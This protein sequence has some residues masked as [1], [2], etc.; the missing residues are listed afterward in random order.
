LASDARGEASATVRERA[1]AARRLQQERQGCLNAQLKPARLRQLAGLAPESRRA[2]ERWGAHRGI[3]ARGFHRAW[4]VAR[5][6][7]DLDGSA[8]TEDH[9]ILDALGFRLQAV[10]AC[11]QDERQ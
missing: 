2:L 6:A 4:R 3:T 1:V 5:T 7:A 9:H 8:Q 10:P 11:L